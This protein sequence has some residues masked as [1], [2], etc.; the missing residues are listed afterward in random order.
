[1]V[2][3]NNEQN[4]IRRFLLEQ[5]SDPERQ[6]FELRLLSED[7]LWEEVE[8]VEDEL[9]DD[10]LAG[11]LSST[12]RGRFD[13]VFVST[14][15]RERKLNAGQVMRRYFKPQPPPA[16]KPNWFKRLK[17]WIGSSSI[18]IAVPVAVAAM[19]IIGV[20]IWR[21]GYYPSDVDKGLVALNDA[22]R[23]QRPIEGRISGIDHA[24][25]IIH[26]SNEPLP[27]NEL[28]RHRADVLLTEAVKQ[29]PGPRTYHA[30]GKLYLL[31]RDLP[32]AI[33]YLEQAK[34][35]DPGNPQ[36]YADLGAAYLEKGKLELETARANE[37]DVNAG[38]GSEDLARSLEYLKQAL[39]LNPNLLE[40]LFNRALVHE[41]QQLYGQAKT[42][43]RTYLEKDPNSPWAND[44][45]KHLKDLEENNSKSQKSDD[46]ATSFLTAFMA[47]DENGAWEIFKRNHGSST[48]RI[49]QEL[50]NSFLK[51]DADS[52]QCLSALNYLGQLQLRKTHD[53]FT[54]DLAAVYTSTTPDTRAILMEARQQIAGASK[55]VREARAGEALSLFDSAR[56]NFQKAGDLPESLSTEAAIAQAAA[57]QPDLPKAQEALSR[58]VPTAES[59]NYKWLLAQ[60]ITRQAHIEANLNNYSKAISDA[61]RAMQLFRQADD[62]SGILGSFIQL[63]SL[64]LFLNDN[65]TS[66]SYL[67]RALTLSK[68]EP[69]A[70]N[71]IWGIHTTVS[72]NLTAL[73]L[74]RAALDYQNEALQLALESKAPIIISRSYQYI[75]LT[76][77]SLRQFDLALQN[78]RLAYDA[79][80]ALAGERD[81]QSMMANASLK[82]GDLYR[83]RGDPANAVTAYD[84]SLRL[85]DALKFG[86]Y[87][88]AAHKGKFLTY[89]ALNNDA[90]A[91]QELQLVLHLFDEYREKIQLER[92][93]M[94]FFDREQDIYD[95]AIDFTY[96]RL[97]DKWRAFD[98]AEISRARNLRELIHQGAEVNQSYPGL[99]L[100]TAEATPPQSAGAL[101]AQEIQQRLPERVQ[102][103]QY[104]VLEKKLVIWIVSRSRLATESVDVESAKLNELIAAALKQIMARD[105]AAATASLKSLYKLIIE[106]VRDK[107]EPGKVLCFIPD[108]VLHFLPFTALMSPGSGHYLL[109]EFPILV[110]PSA[111]LLIESSKEAARRP[112]VKQEHL[113]AVGN[114][115]FDRRTNPN[116]VNLA[117]AER[118]VEQIELNYPLRQV[119]VGP[120]AIR[121]T[122]MKGIT[123]AEVAHFAA[124]FEIDPRSSLSSNLLLG[125]EPGD[126]AHAQ[127]SGLS[128]AD[129]YQIKLP[130]T[131][132]VVLSGCQTGVEQQ[133]AGEGSIGFA[134]S[135]L[136]AGV[137]VVVASL[138][139][140]D[141]DATSDLMI[142]FHHFRRDKKYP[143]TESLRLAQLQVMADGN[144]RSPYYWAGFTVIGGY[145]SY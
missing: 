136:V 101:S 18:P 127:Q 91:S 121:S 92:Q 74:Y 93:K 143:T 129:I 3:E 126:R 132:L 29:N 59:R 120:K 111:R 43:W 68:R 13:E 33:N 94:F 138:W 63:A 133:F 113:L 116:A 83:A 128:A 14:P 27:V 32:A 75:G 12:D 104:A 17:T 25:F 2:H 97:G 38:K 24:P 52:A 88:Y 145:A 56:N 90:L 98:Y 141:S 100:E 106:P 66:F 78:S 16:P 96:S 69:V 81:G 41:H 57:L 80:A 10:Y 7:D 22:Y 77:G 123:Q 107:L 65:K 110:S 142:A 39:D 62:T 35:A 8:F 84:E 23:S 31:A 54:A 72:L 140:V 61:N 79:G 130:R 55:L 36:I 37:N 34:Q 85:Y 21:G 60:Y 45:R 4:T 87:R 67:E 46:T 1:M 28:E 50:I 105:D 40:A 47:G 73:K 135:F 9:I 102:L 71:D 108:K 139:P 114:P 109:E 134:R 144:Y 103:V 15:E 51:N 42:D 115:S 6:N 82:L 48:N 70:V 11:E 20:I 5:L 137:P 122:I 117:S 86:H 95:L 118:E 64:Y 26:R 125:P 53:P 119:L 89:L 124:H 131:R 58:S 19:I 76:Y 112:A 30:A 99:D 49:T 44:A